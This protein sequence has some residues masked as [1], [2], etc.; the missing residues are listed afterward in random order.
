MP[1]DTLFSGVAACWSW[2]PLIVMFALVKP[3]RA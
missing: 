1:L 3:L 2:R